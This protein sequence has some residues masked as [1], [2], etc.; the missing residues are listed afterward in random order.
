MQI[1]LRLDT[2]FSP[3]IAFSARR[4]TSLNATSGS[5]LNFNMVHVNEGNR[6]ISSRFYVTIPGAYFIALSIAARIYDLAG[7][8]VMINN[9]VISQ[10][11]YFCIF[12]L[13]K[14]KFFACIYVIM[15]S[16]TFRHFSRKYLASLFCID[17]LEAIL[18]SFNNESS[19]KLYNTHVF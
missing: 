17:I 14:D 8:Y 3:L 19:S 12:S 15:N 16:N 4:S 13:L 2:R 7:V 9:Q 6:F 1:G 11:N 18:T 5:L 10:N